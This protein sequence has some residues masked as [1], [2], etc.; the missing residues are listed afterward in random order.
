MPVLYLWDGRTG[1]VVLNVRIQS[2][3][4]TGDF[5]NTILHP[6]A[7]RPSKSSRERRMKIAHAEKLPYL[8][9]REAAELLGVST[10]ALR[11]AAYQGRVRYYRLGSGRTQQL[12]FHPEDLTS[13]RMRLQGGRA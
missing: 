11:M 1:A 10:T 6:R 8:T 12:I 13:V 9:S 4:T 7:G 3:A 2:I 5:V